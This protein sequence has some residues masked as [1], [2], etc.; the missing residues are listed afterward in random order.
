MAKRMFLTPG[1]CAVAMALV[2]TSAACSGGD[3]EDSSE[4]KD[5]LS[6]HQ[7][8][9]IAQAEPDPSCATEPPAAPADASL[10]PLEVLKL[11]GT[12]LTT[13]TEHLP[14]DEVEQRRAELAKDPNVVASSVARPAIAEQTGG[15]DRRGAQWGLDALGAPAGASQL[16]WP[17]GSGS[18]LAV[19][20]TGVDA[21]HPDLG[22]AV[23]GRRHYP[24]ED[25]LDPGEHGTH[26]AGIMAARPD[27]G[28]IVGVAPAAKLLDVPIWMAEGGK[29]VNKPAGSWESALVWAVNNGA[30]AANMSFSQP[31]ED[32][33]E[34][35]L[36]FSTAAAD[37]AA[38]NDTVLVAAAGNCGGKIQ[39]VPVLRDCAHRNERVV[40]ASLPGVV[41]VGAVEQAGDQATDELTLT[42]FSTK[43]ED[44][45]IVAPGN[46]ILSTLPGDKYE[47]W[48]GTSMAAPFVTAAAGVARSEQP[49]AGDDVII[50]A[51]VGS[52][53]PRRLVGKDRGNIGAGDGFLDIAGM[54]DELQA[55]DES[56]T[57]DRG[58][59]PTQAAWA[60]DGGT[61][62]FEFDG[63]QV[64]E[65]TEINA[66]KNVR[67]IRWSPD[68]TRMI[69]IDGATLF[70]WSV[71]DG[72]EPAV[73]TCQNCDRGSVE[74]L[75]APKGKDLVVEVNYD[76]TLLPYDAVTLEPLEQQQKELTF[77][78]KGQAGDM[79]LRGSADGQLFVEQSGG[80]HE[81]ETLWVIDPD[82][83]KAGAS[84]SILGQVRD[85]MA[86][87]AGGEEIAFQTGYVDCDATNRVYVI[88]ADDLSEV[89]TPAT[90]PGMIVDDLFFNGDALYASMISADEASTPCTRFGNAGL[91]RLEGNGWKQVDTTS[92]I[93][94]R[95]LKGR[96]G[97]ATAGW[98]RVETTGHGVFNPPLRDDPAKGD[99]GPVDLNLLL[100]STPTAREVDP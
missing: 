54:L 3:D 65:V 92:S 44:V 94:A 100:W 70:S 48:P 84:Y 76:G 6:E 99:V 4:A 14:E 47:A 79:T 97:A 52:A 87:S 91:W 37:F 68:G 38:R 18:L 80:A 58:A 85:D 72:G 90:P 82:S 19:I 15:D 12:C 9:L 28:G 86:V 63:K 49:M 10:V 46:E 7:Q 27:N 20:D 93:A 17:D 51:I 50:R 25:E 96:T 98:L 59:G 61:T 35:D 11:D 60:E 36:Q 1:S 73:T 74:Y 69:G 8:E 40:P 2:L 56:Q 42:G 66:G 26:V 21:G 83:G 41:A 22:D 77:P 33:T 88:G 57:I 39:S 31:L 29:E 32:F 78:P 43:N 24:G 55:A 71:K 45:D 13:T 89:A 95:P 75:D 5:V 23:A 81:S 64:H 53:D 16:G 34:E 67:S 30:D 62:L